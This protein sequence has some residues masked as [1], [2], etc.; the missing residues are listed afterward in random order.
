MKLW[1][2]RFKNE[3]SKLMEDFNSSLKFDKRLYKEDIKGSIAHVKM[4]SKCE[5]L[6]KEEEILIIDGLLSILNDIE[7]GVLKIEGDYEDIHSFVEINL[8]KRI[9]EVGKKLHTGRSRNDQ[10]AVDMRMYAKNKA[11]EII[12]YIDE[13]MLVIVNLG[14]N[15]DAIMPGYTHL[16]R[17]QVV[18]FK[19]HIM[20]YYSMFN[21]DKSRILSDIEIMDE[22]PLGCGALAGTTYNIDRSFT[23]KE[24]GF[25]K[26][27]DNFMDGVS[28]RD[29][30][31]SLLSSFSIIMMHLSRL[32]EELI[33]W[34]SKEFDFI[35]I[36]DKFATGSSIMPQ[37]KNPDA[38]ELIRGKTGR[39]YGSLM[40]LLTTM[41]G[42]PLAYNK[43]MQEDKEGFFDAVDTIIKSLKIMSEMLDS[44]E[45]KKE[46]MYNAVKKGFLNATEAADYLVNK[47]MAF[48]DAHRVI[49]TIVL[50]CEDN[51][52]AIEDLTL[53]KLKSFCDLFGE[54]VYEFIDYKNSL[55]RGIKIDI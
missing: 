6:K 46:N 30:L 34:S 32:S 15:N 41:K 25:K 4:L 47:G 13:L 1:G 43:D 38:A 11:Y 19:F 20:A 39:V 28:D 53:D 48:R 8:I 23:A 40:G 54:D 49:G 35:K 16:Q 9:G 10:V 22:S 26:P 18:K 2:G 24:L 37:K 3:E 36:S 29:Y 55:K 17:A 52:V 45:I 27:V 12:K 7:S 33:L 50:Y 5:I 42:L 31:I 14:E 51:G 21:R 44:L